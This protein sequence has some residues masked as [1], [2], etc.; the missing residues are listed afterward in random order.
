MPR[1]HD[2]KF[3]RNIG[4]MAH[5]DA[6]KTTTTER[7]LYYTGRIH[8][9]GEVHE[10]T[11]T[12]DWMDQ[13]KERGVTITAAATTCF[14]KDFRINIIDTPG[15]V[16]F[17]AE[18]ERSLRVLDGV[19]AI[20][21]GV[22]GVEPQSETVWRQAARY[23]I[24]CIAYV[25]KMDRP[26][27]DFDRTIEKMRER[28]GANAVPIVRPLGKE[29]GFKGV[30]DLIRKKAYIFNEEDLGLTF[31][32]EDPPSQMSDEVDF[33]RD[34]LIQALAE[35]DERV[36]EKYI[37]DKHPAPEEIKSLIRKFTL[38]AKF[39]PVYCGS[40]LR[41]KGIQPLL[42]GIIEYLPSPLDAGSVKGNN[43]NTGREEERIPGD[44]EPLA[45]LAF[46]IVTDMHVGRLTYLRI[47]SGCMK[48]GDYI[49]NAS[50]GIK[51]RIGRL[52]LMHANKREEVEE[53]FS[54][55]IVAAIGLKETDTGDTITDLK[56]P[57][58][59]ESMQFPEPVISVAIEPDTK[60]DQ[61]KL[62][63]SLGKLSNEDPTFKVKVDND[64]GQTVISGMGEFHLEVL[65]ERLTREFGVN[66]RVGKPQVAYK[67]TI[68]RPSQA[69]GKFIKQTGGRGQYGHVWLSIEP[70]EPSSG[71]KFY[72]RIKQG[73]IPREFIPA[74]EDGVKGSIESGALAGYPIV[75]VAVSLIDG[76]F[77]D[78]D[79]SALAFEIAGSQAFGKAVALAEPYLLEPVMDVEIITPQD[80]I[81]DIIGDLNARRGRVESTD[82]RGVARVIR[83]FV[84]LSEMFGYA[85]SM[86]SLTQGRATYTMEFERYE[87]VPKHVADKILLRTKIKE[88]EK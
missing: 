22:G 14:W 33:Y 73:V 38:E 44:K 30:V 54:G 77:H 34:K 37:Q 47:Y 55:E 70:G 48:T 13:E 11:A 56:H 49:Y 35:L 64:T 53:V 4:T 41:Y 16:D 61:D 15:H 65:V 74:V 27:S 28:L 25:N 3:I 24:P 43:L 88:K 10:G 7:M 75:D 79:S 23:H 69:E 19:L 78:V 40:S 29:E 2:L 45:S 8:R 68:R 51:E 1:K 17:T 36:M 85:T 52:I 80:F 9:M 83:A 18:V 39:V 60:A 57:L 59:F 26:G 50:K 67:E 46:K 72:N 86:R 6:G 58:I 5:I 81:G 71:F 12:M 32:E 20:F 76:S 87:E 21:C 82:T 42:D 84:P 63:E 66:A 62:G 31:R